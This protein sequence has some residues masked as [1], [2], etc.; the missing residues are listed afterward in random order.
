MKFDIQDHHDIGFKRCGLTAR[1]TLDLTNSDVDSV[2]NTCFEN[3][4]HCE[5]Y[6]T[7]FFR[8][9]SLPNLFF[10]NSYTTDG[11]NGLPGYVPTTVQRH[12][13]STAASDFKRF[14]RAPSLFFPWDRSHFRPVA[15][16]SPVQGRQ[17]TPAG[18][19]AEPDASAET[20]DCQFALAVCATTLR[21]QGESGWW[22]HDSCVHSIIEV[23]GRPSKW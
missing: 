6:S 16:R 13:S 2:L 7:S 8:L 10:C 23:Y 4:L 15:P 1:H 22:R 3:L 5:K 18:G 19:G 21:T 11:P 14:Q 9:C 12:S 17:S 20:P